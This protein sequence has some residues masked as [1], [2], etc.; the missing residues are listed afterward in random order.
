MDQL[1][2][3]FDFGSFTAGPPP[4]GGPNDD[5]GHHHQLDFDAASYGAGQ[6]LGDAG[7]SQDDLAWLEAQLSLA[8]QHASPPPPASAPSSFAPLASPNGTETYVHQPHAFPPVS[9]SKYHPY[10]LP[11]DRARRIRPPGPSAHLDLVQPHFQQHRQPQPHQPHQH[12]QQ[13]H[14]GAAATYSVAPAQGGLDA[15]QWPSFSS[16]ASSFAPVAAPPAPSAHYGQPSTPYY[17]APAAKQLGSVLYPPQDAPSPV[18]L[19]DAPTPTYPVAPHASPATPSTLQH[20]QTPP[21]P[22]PPLV[23]GH[24]KSAA[25]SSNGLSNGVA[26]PRPRRPRAR[27][28]PPPP[29]PPSSFP[30]APTPLSSPPQARPR[31]VQ[32]LSELFA[33][34]DAQR[35]SFATLFSALSDLEGSPAEHERRLGEF[36]EMDEPLTASA[37]GIDDGEEPTDGARLLREAKRRW[38]IKRRQDKGP[39]R[40]GDEVGA[41][42]DDE[43]EER[44][45]DEVVRMWEE[46]GGLGRRREGTMAK[47]VRELHSNVHDGAVAGSV[48]R[49]IIN[50]YGEAYKESSTDIERL[51]A[52]LKRPPSP[53]LTSAPREAAVWTGTLVLPP[54]QADVLQSWLMSPGRPSLGGKIDPEHMRIYSSL[55]PLDLHARG[56]ELCRVVL[57]R[58]AECM[59]LY[60]HYFDRFQSFKV[61]PA[62]AA[63]DSCGFSSYDEQSLWHH[64]LQTYLQLCVRYPPFREGKDA[65]ITILPD[66]PPPVHPTPLETLLIDRA[67]HDHWEHLRV[68]LLDSH[69]G[70]LRSAVRAFNGVKLSKFDLL[71]VCDDTRAVMLALDRSKK[72]PSERFLPYD[73][74]ISQIRN[75]WRQQA[76]YDKTA[77]LV[78]WSA[79]TTH[80]LEISALHPDFALGVSHLPGLEALLGSKAAANGAVAMQH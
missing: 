77:D 7:L 12:Q 73:P 72:N 9:S 33:W 4:A 48:I 2:P 1:P 80:F 68:F 22:S 26:R 25:W 43:V 3:A 66:L 75:A 56:A 71:S 78:V 57:L 63:I 14:Q 69:G 30:R 31:K 17:A 5:G 37:G 10:S 23:N 51:D 40:E 61:G 55:S 11:P 52:A 42:D 13:Y 74:A 70:L 39:V 16:F 64:A 24:G 54:T 58:D 8:A 18:L 36:L 29:A 32:Q 35:W 49:R 62:I 34:L 76:Y 65:K 50:R 53:H 27:S 41:G 21:V 47:A 46:Q 79:A 20:I 45:P 60:G 38:A 44:G 15:L 19:P 67:L 6:Q 59:R 28:A